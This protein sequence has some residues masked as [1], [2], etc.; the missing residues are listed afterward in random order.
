MRRQSYPA[1]RLA[2]AAPE[3]LNRA[4]R[5]AVLETN[6]MQRPVIEFGRNRVGAAQPDFIER[7]GSASMILP[8][9]LRSR[10]SNHVRSP[11]VARICLDTGQRKFRRLSVN[12]R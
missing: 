7:C 4:E 12:Q 6:F 8:P 2:L 5:G 11:P 10:H 1:Q 3:F 9:A